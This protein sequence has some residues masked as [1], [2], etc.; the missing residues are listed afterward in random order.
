MHERRESHTTVLDHCECCV[1]RAHCVSG[2]ACVTV[3]VTACVGR[4]ALLRCRCV[5][6]GSAWAPVCMAAA[7]N[8]WFPA[9]VPVR[10]AD[11]SN[12]DEIYV[13]TALNRVLAQHPGGVP[14]KPRAS[15]YGDP[16]LRIVANEEARV[17]NPEVDQSKWPENDDNLS[18]AERLE[19][20]NER[21]EAEDALI[22]RQQAAELRR[23]SLKQ[24]SVQQDSKQAANRAKSA[25]RARTNK[26]K[27]SKAKKQKQGGKRSPHVR[28]VQRS[29]PFNPDAIPA[30]RP[31]AADGSICYKEPVLSGSPEF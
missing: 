4:C 31:T 20:R 29:P 14:R 17:W 28:A 21:I 2:C 11:G 3:C 16:I 30:P 9:V 18:A 27:E 6:A 8:N 13:L 1:Q 5:T 7:A 12:D 22:F 25:K 10:R 26:R 19:K 24:Q 15:Q 23:L